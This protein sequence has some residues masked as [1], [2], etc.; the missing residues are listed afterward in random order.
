MMPVRR[1][2]RIALPADRICDWHKDGPAVTLFLNAQSL[3][4]PAGERFFMDAVR[5]YRDQVTDP[6]LKEQVVAFI[7]Q[8][9]M[10]SREHQEYNDLMDAAGLPASKLDRFAWKYTDWLRT[11]SHKR[12]LS[13]TIALEHYTAMLA[14]QA[15]KDPE[16][17]G[18]VK[19]YQQ[20]W[21]WHAMEETEHKS[22][23]FDV[24]RTVAK[25]GPISYL[26]R[27]F[28]MTVTSLL[29]WAT[30]F[31]YHSTLLGAYLRKGGKLT[32]GDWGRLIRFIWSPR[33]GTFARIARELIDYY[34]PGFHPWDHDNRE[35]LARVDTL[36]D[37]I[38]Q[39]N[40]AHAADAQVRRVPLHPDAQA[41]A[42]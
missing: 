19:A 24:W 23:A 13:I 15:L 16:N 38:S 9:A 11:F 39:T 20:L 40:Q 31:V 7:G 3:L 18:G 27:T 12:W 21:L 5:N 33:T 34:R 14:N 17:I 10:H 1:D 25:P 35:Y 26:R 37:E 41:V 8:E 32:L 36:L 29:F 2:V 22:V 28:S 4:F 30:V 6:V 42:A